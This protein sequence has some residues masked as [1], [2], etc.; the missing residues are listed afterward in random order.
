M[1]KESEFRE[2][3]GNLTDEEIEAYGGMIFRQLQ[4]EEN[5]INKE[6]KE[7]DHKKVGEDTKQDK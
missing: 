3:Y 7:D 6:K 5:R 4:E 2:I 1:S